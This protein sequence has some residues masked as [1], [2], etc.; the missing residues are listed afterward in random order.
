M[1][2]FS[3]RI[4]DAQRQRLEALGA[5][6][7]LQPADLIRNAVTALL[8]YAEANGGKVVFPLRF[9]AL[10]DSALKGATAFQALD[11]ITRDRVIKRVNAHYT[12]PVIA[13]EFVHLPP[14]SLADLKAVYD[15]LQSSQMEEEHESRFMVAE[16]KP[17]RQQPGND[18]AG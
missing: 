2:N 11:E 13:K 6:L 16:P 4:S 18:Q 9:E 12:W 3:I 15:F 17:K 1:K 5:A 14:Q 10:S 7:E 8:L